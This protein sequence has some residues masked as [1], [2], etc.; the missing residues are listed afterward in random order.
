MRTDRYHPWRDF[1][2]AE[3]WVLEMADLPEHVQGR[4]DFPAGLVQVSRRLDQAG[5]RST[6]AHELVHLER[7]PVSSDPRLRRIE[8]RDVEAEAARRLVDVQHLV[9]AVQWSQ[10]PGEV[11]EE[12]WV[13]VATLRARVACLSDS[14]R[15]QIEDAVRAV[16]RL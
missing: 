13:D 11:A 7:G 8:E 14:E 6:I 16:G 3:E 2:G 12:C 9:S 10:W 15:A 5:R 4:T 1:R